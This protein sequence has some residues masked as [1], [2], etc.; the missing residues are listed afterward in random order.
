VS[1]EGKQ[2]SCLL[3]AWESNTGAMPQE[4]T[5]GREVVP[6]P[7]RATAWRESRAIPTAPARNTK[8]SW[9]LY[10]H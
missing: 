3:C 7:S 10:A 2:S 6:R 9:F 4:A 5:C 8:S 1:E